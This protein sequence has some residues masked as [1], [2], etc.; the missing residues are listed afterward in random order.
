MQLDPFVSAVFNILIAF[1]GAL[2]G[3]TAS[4]TDLFG[5]G[6]AQKIV[7]GVGIASSVLGALNGA[8]HGYSPPTSG[9]FNKS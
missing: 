8:L 2:A 4:L 3:A 9:P 1:C 6:P 7:A 5:Q